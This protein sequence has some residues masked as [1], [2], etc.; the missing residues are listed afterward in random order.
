MEPIWEVTTEGDCE[1]KA[2]R[3]LGVFTGNPVDIAFKLAD[4]AMYTL[5]FHELN[6]DDIQTFEPTRETIA[7]RFTYGDKYHTNDITARKATFEKLIENRPVKITN[8]VPG[9]SYITLSLTDDSNL[10]QTEIAKALA[11]LT[12][13]EKELL[14]LK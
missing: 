14:G 1:G 11:K 13:E 6:I 10:K 4:K 3:K 9:N 5:F 12:E 2:I 7:M 8:N